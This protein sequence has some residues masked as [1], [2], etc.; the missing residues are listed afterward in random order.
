MTFSTDYG[1]EVYEGDADV[2]GAAVSASQ[3]QAL[4]NGT[5]AHSFVGFPRFIE[6]SYFDLLGGAVAMVIRQ[7]EVRIHDPRTVAG[8]DGHWG[9]YVLPGDWV[10]ALAAVPAKNIW[11]LSH[12]WRE[13]FLQ[14]YGEHE[15][16]P[17]TELL[18]P[19]YRLTLLCQEALSRHTDVVLLAI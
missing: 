9:A 10:A 14:V 19:L 15:A 4:R 6:G 18:D 11:L 3:W 8:E 5:A 13:A 1:C 2:I 7:P 17:D 16:W 12:H